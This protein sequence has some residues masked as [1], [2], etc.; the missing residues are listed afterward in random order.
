ME[1]DSIYKKTPLG[2]S[3]MNNRDSTLSVMERRV[4]IVI[5]GIKDIKSVEKLSISKEIDENIESLINLKFIEPMTV[6]VTSTKLPTSAS[7]W[8]DNEVSVVE[9]TGIKDLMIN[10]LLTFSNRVRTRD[11]IN[12]INSTE[13]LGEVKQMIQPWYTAIS[14]TPN[15]MYE[16]DNLK[17]RVLEMVYKADTN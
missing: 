6:E 10:T 15:G 9:G 4:L 13:T 14:E 5:D 3:E 11:L 16:A 17:S 8:S 12:E 7:E 2:V 1:H